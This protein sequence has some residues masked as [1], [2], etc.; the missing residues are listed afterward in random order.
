MAS[1]MASLSAVGSRSRVAGGLPQPGRGLGRR[2]RAHG[3]FACACLSCTQLSTAFCAACTS[4]GKN[5]LCQVHPCVPMCILYI[6]KLMGALR[7]HNRQSYTLWL[8]CMWPHEK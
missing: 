8:S 6:L 4:R 2:G 5:P 1:L 3:Q 7:S